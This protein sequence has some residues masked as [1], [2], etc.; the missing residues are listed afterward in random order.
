MKHTLGLGHIWRMLGV[1]VFCTLIPLGLG[2]WLD[3]RLDSAPLFVFIFACIGIVTATVGIVRIA[4]RTLQAL[5]SPSEPGA[6]LPGSENGK[7]D[8]A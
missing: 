6:G 4:G 7:E 1:L 3:R 8:R 2:L 5:G